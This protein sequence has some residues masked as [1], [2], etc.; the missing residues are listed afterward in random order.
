MNARRYWAGV[1]AAAVAV[2]VAGNVGH[3]LLTAH[4]AL[5]VPAAVAAALNARPRKALGW[6]TP[7]E[8]FDALL[9]TDDKRPVATTA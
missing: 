5:R 4:A 6:K 3:A 9:Q 8:T 7:A 2:S 1:L